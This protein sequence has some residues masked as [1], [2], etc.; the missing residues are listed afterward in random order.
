MTRINWDKPKTKE[1]LLSRENIDQINSVIRNKRE[2]FTFNGILFTGLRAFEFMHLNKDWVKFISR[3]N[4]SSI[5]RGNINVPERQVCSCK[6]CKY[7]RIKL[8]KRLS[9]IKINEDIEYEPNNIKFKKIWKRKKRLGSLSIRDR[10]MIKGYWVPKTNSSVRT[11][12]IVPQAENIF[13]NYFDNHDT[14]LELLPR[15]I[16][17]NRILN[18]LERRSG[19]KLFPH[20]LRGTFATILAMMGFTPFAIQKALG[21]KS[22]EVAQSYIDYSGAALNREFDNKWNWD[23]I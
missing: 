6:E 15:R 18:R 14:V 21:W 12:P 8:E 23:R 5:I 2:D 1:N 3:S 11:I 20:C 9:K 13:R 4:P 7:K 17:V 22:V 19:I 10:N 16:Y